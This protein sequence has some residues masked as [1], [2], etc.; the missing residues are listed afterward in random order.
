MTIVGSAEVPALLSVYTGSGVG[1][2]QSANNYQ[3]SNINPDGSSYA[4]QGNY[5]S[6]SGNAYDFFGGDAQGVT[7]DVQSNGW[8]AVEGQG[9]V[10]QVDDL[11]HQG[12]GVPP[13]QPGSGWKKP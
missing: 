3:S 10:G 11:S 13:V 12:P 4:Y 2:Y 1:L 8:S 6:N 9:T 7:I 5:A